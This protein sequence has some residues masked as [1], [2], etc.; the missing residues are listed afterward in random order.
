MHSSCALYVII[1]NTVTAQLLDNSSNWI[2]FFEMYLCVVCFLARI[3][4]ITIL[5]IALRL[6]QIPSVNFGGLELRLYFYWLS[7]YLSE[8]DPYYSFATGMLPDDLLSCYTKDI[9][10]DYMLRWKRGW[11]S[12]AWWMLNGI[13]LDEYYSVG[14]YLVICHWKIGSC[15]ADGSADGSTGTS[16]YS[17]SR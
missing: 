12:C 13:V 10:F 16:N 1:Y 15:Y 2:S 5:L 17:L 14:R 7:Y 3:I 4:L 6:V 8:P 9:W 11:W